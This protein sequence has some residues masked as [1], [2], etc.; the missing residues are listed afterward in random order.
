VTEPSADLSEP[1]RMTAHGVDPDR[2]MLAGVDVSAKPRFTTGE[3]G[4][5]FFA[6]SPHWMRWVERKGVLD[7][8]VVDPETGRTT[9][10]KLYER[11]PAGA[12]IFTLDVIELIIHA[13]AAPL[14][15]PPPGEK[16]KRPPITGEQAARAL[17]VVAAIARVHGYLPDAPDTSISTP[18]PT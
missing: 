7:V 8:Q 12:R 11:T 9:T 2:L 18:K 5:I 17:A 4:K 1:V 16:P 10:R 13:L 6:F 14:P 3:C 15:A